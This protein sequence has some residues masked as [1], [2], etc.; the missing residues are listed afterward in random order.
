MGHGLFLRNVDGARFI[1]I[2]VF[3]PIKPINVKFVDILRSERGYRIAA[4]GK[5]CDVGKAR[6]L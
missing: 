5:F 2:C 6:T 3:T 1:P 4:A